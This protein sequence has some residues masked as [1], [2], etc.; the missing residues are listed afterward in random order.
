MDILT[1]ALSSMRT[2]QPT[3]VRTE[4][5][6][7]WGLRI[8]PVSGAGFHIVL[9]GTCWLVP[10]DGASGGRPIPLGPG[11]VV[12]LRGGA[13][14][15]LADHPSTPYA[16]EQTDQYR[17]SL[18]IGTVTVGGD[19]PRT[20]LLCGHYRLD[21]SRPHPLLR[22]LPDIVHLPAG[23]GRHVELGAAV[24]LLAAELETPRIGST[25]IVPALIDSLLLYIL[26]AWLDDQPRTGGAGWAAA[27]ED[28]AVAPALNAIH[29]DPAHPWT[30]E[31]LAGRGCPGPPS[32]AGS[33]P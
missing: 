6:A 31:A 30:V 21:Q 5:R 26:R 19:G 11:D 10:L 14:C 20:S 4:G 32:P 9:S 2:G 27:F 33:P 15:V 24:R 8:P 25:G 13:G 7:P 28:P 3:S 23:P 1:E 22:Q 29:E 18:P 16:R 12:F 17:D